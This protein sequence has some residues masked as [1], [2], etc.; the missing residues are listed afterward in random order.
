MR[1][2]ACRACFVDSSPDN[3]SIAS[4]RRVLCGEHFL[5]GSITFTFDG[6]E[7]HT[8]KAGEAYHETP[9]ENMLAKN[10]SASEDLKI[11]VFQVGTEGKAV[12]IQAN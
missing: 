5:E 12:M 4:K 2:H 11:I 6:K 1:R 7:P 3:H 8:V 9:N 10:A